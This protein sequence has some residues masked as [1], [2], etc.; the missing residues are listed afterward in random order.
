MSFIKF[1]APSE[2][3]WFKTY[4]TY[5]EVKTLP[6]FRTI[7]G[8]YIKYDRVVYDKLIKKNGY[9]SKY[10]LRARQKILDVIDDLPP[11]L[12]DLV[13]ENFIHSKFNKSKY[14]LDLINLPPTVKYINI[15][16]S[17]VTYIPYSIIRD[18]DKFHTTNSNFLRQCNKL[19]NGDF[20]KYCRYREI[21]M[22]T[23]KRR[24]EKIENWFIDCKYN[25]EYKYCRDRVQK[26]YEETYDD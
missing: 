25:P 5:N 19:F 23:H 24:I 21:C 10:I 16:G 17:H 22:R 9:N 4:N 26:D 13:F 11:N 7:H 15:R 20:K 18:L 3:G 12:E 14:T 1:R 2:I 6:H 8:I